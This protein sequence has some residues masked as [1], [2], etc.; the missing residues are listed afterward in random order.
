MA[1]DTELDF[2]ADLIA[3][4]R[5]AGADA[6]DAVL[7]DH[8]SM[9]A[10]ARMGRTEDIERAESS[11]LGLRVL[12]GRRQAVASSSDRT[13]KAL[14]ELVARAVAM[15][16]AAPE[17]PY[18]GLAAPE[19]VTDRI[20]D[21]DICDPVE[22]SPDRLSARAQEAEDA[23]R[24]VAGV[25]NSEGA[26]AG[27]S[28]TTVA[29]AASNGFAGAYAVSRHMLSVSVLAGEGTAMERD[30]DYAVAVHGDDLDPPDA[31]GRAA[32]ERAVRRLRPRKAKSAR[33]PVVYDQRVAG[34]L[35]RH[36]AGAIN[37][38]AIARGTSF[39]KDRMG[40][41]IFPK[42][43][44]IRDD[45]LRA[46]GLAS[47]P[48]DGEGLAGAPRAVIDAGTLTTW[49][50]DIGTAR[51]LG[52]ASTGHAARGTTSPPAPAASNLWMEAGPLAPEALIAEID[53]G[54]LVTELIG[55]GVNLV[56]GDY[57]RGAAGFWIEKGEIAY[58]VSE[59]TVAGNLSDMY[60]NL[61]AASDLRF[62]HGTDAPTLRVDGMTIAGL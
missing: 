43:I 31:L 1:A 9:S 41:R 52:L 51:Q 62:R 24:A 56:T 47:H 12:I 44:T 40:E 19:A 49:F 2:L 25:T 37:G 42:A 26:E 59:I 36:L 55:M 27:W 33:L 8:V 46:R 34:G 18:C 3:A 57:S 4:A 22:P 39:L 32:G 10:A 45:P 54:L 60:A 29:L 58:P 61:T 50:L 14:A 30:Y 17:D 23:A 21:L 28:R 6:A 35:V 48:F 13:P 5:R 15:A 11:A 7:L 38:A 53:Q 16:K 20:P